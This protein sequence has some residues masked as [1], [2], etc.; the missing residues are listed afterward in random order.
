MNEVSKIA[1]TMDEPLRILQAHV[2]SHSKMNVTRDGTVPSVVALIVAGA[3]RVADDAGGSV[4]L[5]APES[6][7]LT[8]G[9]TVVSG[10]DAPHYLGLVEDPDQG[11]PTCLAALQALAKIGLYVYSQ[12]IDST[13]LASLL[14]ADHATAPRAASARVLESLTPMARSLAYATG[15]HPRTVVKLCQL[16]DGQRKDT[17]VSEVLG[18][19]ITKDFTRRVQQLW[20]RAT[21]EERNNFVAT[22]ILGETVDCTEPCSPSVET[23]RTS[24]WDWVRRCGLI[25]GVGDEFVPRVSPIM[26]R[27]LLRRLSSSSL[28]FYDCLKQQVGGGLTSSWSEWETLCCSREWVHSIARSLRSSVNDEY[29][30]VTLEWLLGTLSSFCGSGSL[31]KDMLVDASHARSGWSHHNLQTLL[32]W[33]GTSQEID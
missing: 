31:L 20:M 3:C 25:Y 29:S 21:V 28:L 23:A 14:Q 16:L 13:E 15:G 4:M 27:R 33:E 11:I 30:A 18:R 6:E 24:S 7:L 17:S 10:R 8:E 5:T 9:V 1:N 2:A 32:S 19:V 26:L 22:L 12:E